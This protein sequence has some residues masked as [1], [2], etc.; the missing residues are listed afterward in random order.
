MNELLSGLLAQTEA[1]R[2]PF[3]GPNPGGVDLWHEPELEPLQ[4]EV[5]KLEG[6][7]AASVDW[8][9]LGQGASDLLASRTKDVRLAAWAA[10]AALGG[11]GWPELARALVVLRAIVTDHWDTAFPTRVKARVNQI[12][13]LY[14]RA[15]GPIGAL[16]VTEREGD[17]VRLCEAL[18]REI[19]EALRAK[20]AGAYDGLGLLQGLLRQR[21]SEIPAPPPPPPPP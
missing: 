20:A 7:H 3:A 11:G 17:A 9:A 19:D 8:A 15:K 1:E 4:A 2:A 6:L 16:A 13:W 12:A 18:F 5:R 10:A 14:E 21:V